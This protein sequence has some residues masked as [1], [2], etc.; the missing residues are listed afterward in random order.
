MTGLS[1]DPTGL[2][3]DA[4]A[5]R[6]QTLGALFNAEFDLLAFLQVLEAITLDGGVM[7]KDIRSALTSDEAVALVSI[8]PLDRSDDTF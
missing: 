2:G 6:L 1:C 7:H 3:D 8:E 4:D 5:G